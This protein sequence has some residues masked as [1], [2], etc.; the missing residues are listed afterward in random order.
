MVCILTVLILP[1]HEHGG[2]SRHLTVGRLAVPRCLPGQRSILKMQV[3]PLV[4]ERA[5][6]ILQPTFQGNNFC[7]PPHVWHLK[8]CGGVKAYTIELVVFLY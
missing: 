5:G 3:L 4:A 1:T 2:E 8:W 7:A 6:K